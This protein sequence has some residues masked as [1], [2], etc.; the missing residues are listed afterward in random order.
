VW[1]MNPNN[2]PSSDSYW[3]RGKEDPWSTW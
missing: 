1:E 2:P 3:D